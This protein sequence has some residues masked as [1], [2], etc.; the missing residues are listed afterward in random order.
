VSVL[1]NPYESEF[2]RFSSGVIAVQTRRGP[3]K[4]KTDFDN[5]EPALRLKRFTL[6]QFT[7]ITLFQPSLA[8][9]GALVPGRVFLEQTAQYHYQT[10]DIPSRPEDELRTTQWF[11]TLTRVDVNLSPQHSLI[12]AGGFFPNSTTQA[13]LGT[14]TPPA[15]TA[16]I[17]G[18]IEHAI[19]AERFVLHRSAFVESTLQLQRYHTDVHGQGSAAMTLLPETTEGNFFNQQHREAS[20]YQWVETISAAH[21]GRWGLHEAKGFVLLYSQYDGTSASGP[22]LIERSDTTLSRRLDFG[23]PTTQEAAATDVA[24]FAQDRLQLA[25]RSYVEVGG[26]LDHDGVAGRVALSP[27]VGTAVLLNASG[28]SVVRAGLGWFYERTPLAAAAFDQFAP[29]TDTRFAADGTTPIGAPV[30]YE[31]VTAPDLEAAGSLTWDVSFDHRVNRLVALHMGLLNRQGSHQLIL[32][33]LS[34]VGGTTGQLLLSSSGRSSFRQADASLHLPLGPRLDGNTSYT[35]SSAREDLNALLVYFDS[36]LNPIVGVNAY[37]PAPA[38]AP[39]RFFVIGRAS[40]GRAWLLVGVLDWRDGLPYSIVDDGLDFVGARN[41][42][43]FP[44]YVRLETGFDRRLHVAHLHP[45]LGLRVVNALNAFLPADVQGNT[46]S[47][48]YGTFYN[49]EYREFRIHLRF[50]R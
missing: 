48:A 11:S 29:A 9:G 4:W 32:D 14:F 5:L 27:R 13:T 18:H 41:D 36:V 44:T 37:A 24:L 38:D 25:S 3:D 19:V 43:R 8:T 50:T 40:P 21:R 28:T 45:W 33:P 35:K 30:L 23:G 26:R 7:G 22:V 10:T 6:F 20:S 1:A 49:S 39:H 2:G 47:P 31:H 16:D 17:G 12:V 34:P 42:H 15:A 46:G